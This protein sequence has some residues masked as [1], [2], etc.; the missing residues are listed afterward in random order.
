[1]ETVFISSPSIQL[2]LGGLLFSRARF[3]FTGQEHPIPRASALS[4]CFVESTYSINYSS[5][6]N[7]PASGSPT[8]CEVAGDCKRPQC[9]QRAPGA[10]GFHSQIDGDKSLRV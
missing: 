8:R 4:S 6:R 3:C 5:T 7:Q 1:M 10:P 2:S 9:I